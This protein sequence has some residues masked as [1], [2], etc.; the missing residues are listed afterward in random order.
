MW[1][2]FKYV[3]SNLTIHNMSQSVIIQFQLYS[4]RVFNIVARG[5]SETVLATLAVIDGYNGCGGL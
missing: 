1:L 4:Y 5:D 3:L 2:N